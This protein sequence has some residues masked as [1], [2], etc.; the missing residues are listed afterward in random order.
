[1]K[2]LFNRLTS[3]GFI[4]LVALL[5]IS[6]LAWAAWMEIDVLSM[7]KGEVAPA[8]QVKVIQHLEGGII[9]AIQVQEGQIVAVNDPLIRLDSTAADAKVATLKSRLL[10]QRVQ[11]IRLEAEA[12][13]DQDL[14]FPATLR[15]QAPTLI[16]K[17]KALFFVRRQRVREQINAQEN[18][19]AQRERELDEIAGRLQNNRQTLSFLEEQ[20]EISQQLLEREITNRMTHLKLLQ[21]RSRLAGKISADE[22]SRPRIEAALAEA[23][24][25]LKA[26]RRGVQ[27]E[28]RSRLAELEQKQR[29]L[30]E[31]LR[32]AQ[33][34]QARTLIKSPVNGIVKILH[35]STLGGVIKPGEPILELVPLD[36]DLIIEARLPTQDIGYVSSGQSARITLLSPEASR[37]GFIRGTVRHISPDTLVSKEGVAFYKVE[38]EPQTKAFHAGQLDYR[39]YPGVQ[40]RC[41]IRIGSRSVLAYLLSP[42]LTHFGMALRE[43]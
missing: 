3:H 28:A 25:K 32:T 41:A 2:T 39:L 24:A 40:V 38:I 36:D 15:E 11:I 5:F 19:I 43:I 30:R 33:D 20:I 21:E 4:A 9:R 22:L 42:W 12:D 34:N 35:V 13:L 31:S 18:V 16:T 17:A 7:A 14:S 6:F 23:R 29:E 1:M 8:S 37:L 10:A 26:L 27:E